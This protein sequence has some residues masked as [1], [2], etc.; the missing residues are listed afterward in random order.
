MQYIISASG[1]ATIIETYVHR[2][3]RGLV[4]SA[5]RNLRLVVSTNISDYADFSLAV[6]TEYVLV[7]GK[8]GL[9]AAV[10]LVGEHS[11]LG[12]LVEVVDVESVV[13]G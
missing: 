3:D 11:L 7:A 6:G 4:G 9:S 8:S 12:A 2:V 13:V 10:A 5:R 1:Y